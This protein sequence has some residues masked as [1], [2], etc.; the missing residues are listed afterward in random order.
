MKA[1]LALHS[2]EIKGDEV[3]EIKIWQ[4]PRAADK[5]HG[6]KF[7]VVYIKNGKRLLGYDNAERRGYHKHIGDKEGPYHFI[8]IWNLLSDFKDDLKKI[9]GRAWDED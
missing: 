6:V 7:S 9:R 4:V 8:D 5:P 3:V 1:N 2:K